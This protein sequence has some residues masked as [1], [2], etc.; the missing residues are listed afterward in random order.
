MNMVIIAAIAAN[1]VIGNDNKLPWRL[2]GD[3]KHFKETTTGGI[4]LMGRK[5][6][7]SIG[8]KPL[9]N[10]CNI[11]LTKDTKLQD[12]F[13]G[14]FPKLVVCH[15]KEEAMKMC[16][17]FSE[18]PT[19][20]KKT[21]FV[22]GG[23]SIYEDFIPMAD[24]M[25]LTRLN[26]DVDGDIKFPEYDKTVWDLVERKTFVEEK[27]FLSTVASEL[28]IPFAIETYKRKENT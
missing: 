11:V 20:G 3:M 25:I 18:L 5:T 10:R 17:S 6:L 15:S 23:R 14:A 7:E 4:V 13:D 16:D 26:I 8:N 22:I 2:P 1:N 24:T 9:P 21:I 12:N 19:I 27:G 28:P